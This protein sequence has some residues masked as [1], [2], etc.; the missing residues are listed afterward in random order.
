MYAMV[1][2][3][4]A[5]ACAGDVYVVTHPDTQVSVADI[6]EVFSGEKQFFGQLRAIPVDNSAVQTDF[7]VK[8]FK[9]SLDRYNTMWT[10]KSF[11]DGI[12]TP[13]LKINDAEV[14]AFIKST[15]GAVGYISKPNTAVKIIE[16]Y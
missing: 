7:L 11:R 6:K 12:I 4:M 9:I 14:I 8:V 13:A 3:Y 2:L 5:S 16:K 10:K 1:T 15:P